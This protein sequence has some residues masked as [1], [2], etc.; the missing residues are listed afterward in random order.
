LRVLM[1]SKACLVGSYQRKLEELARLPGM[2]L[3]V[4]VPPFWRDERGVIH[5]ERAHTQGYELVVEPMAF[6]GHFHVHFYP[7]LARQFKW[8][9]PQVVH[10]DEEP[11][12]LATAQATLLARRAAAR[13]LFFTWQ[14]ILRRYP[15]PFSWIERYTLRRAAFAIAGNADAVNVLR[16]KGY[17][18]P[19]RVIPQFGVDPELF[20]PGEEEKAGDTF[21]VGYVG[22]LV[23]EKGVDDLI[24]AMAE[25]SGPWRLRVVGSGPLRQSLV[26]GARA[27]GVEGRVSFEEQVPS[28]EVPAH[29]RRLDVLVLP[30]RTRPNWKEQFGRVLVEAMS[31]GVAVV[32]SD[33]GEIPRVIEDAGLVFPEGDVQ[34]LRDCLARLLHDPSLLAELG[35]RGRARVLAHYTQAQVAAQTYAIYQ[36]LLS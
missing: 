21:T 34:A 24:H 28:T 14:N 1:I 7:R 25:L 18:G 12:N 2:E 8:V 33:C 6:N 35:R 30:S 11:Y 15:P 31:C 23:A 3:T 22:R 26:A 29:L 16:A 10:I 17:D 32:G 4:V 19:V 5:L 20:S 9:R 13:P 36:A 27:L